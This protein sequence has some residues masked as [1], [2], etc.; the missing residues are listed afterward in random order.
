MSNTVQ[1]PRKIIELATLLIPVKGKL[2]LTPNVTVAEIIY[3]TEPQ[4]QDDVPT[5]FLGTIE[6]R[7]QI[8]PLISFEAINDEPFAGKS[9]QRRIAVFNGLEDSEHLPFYA[10]LT[11]GMP[12]LMRVEA[13]E[14][15]ANREVALG[16]AESLLVNVN[17]EAAVIPNLEYIER[18]ILQ[19]L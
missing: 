8:T 4:A 12:R 1:L 16:V 6:W 3:Y 2:L 7:K 14:V 9:S 19:L 5:W 13:E 10:I 18:Q 17:G 11:Q 15:V